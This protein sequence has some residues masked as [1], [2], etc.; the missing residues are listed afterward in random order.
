MV[1]ETLGSVIGLPQAV[2]AQPASMAR[3][4]HH[5]CPHLSGF[6]AGAY[7]TPNTLLAHY[8]KFELAFDTLQYEHQRSVAP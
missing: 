6:A 4:G 5:G 1:G 3:G 7:G 2:P 8:R